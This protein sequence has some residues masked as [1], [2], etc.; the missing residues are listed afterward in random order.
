MASSSQPVRNARQHNA[1]V[2]SKATARI[3]AK[4]VLCLVSRIRLIQHSLSNRLCSRLLALLLQLAAQ[5]FVQAFVTVVD[6]ALQPAGKFSR[7][8]SY[9]CQPSH[10]YPDRI[11][12]V[13]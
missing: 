13:L 11:V 8:A 7:A 4:H 9:A 3:K 6:A 2:S 5:P 10:A 1:Q 12:D